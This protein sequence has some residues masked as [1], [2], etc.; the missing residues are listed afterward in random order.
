M[1]NIKKTK[2]YDKFV[3]ID[4]NRDIDKGLQS[5]LNKS[6]DVVSPRL[7]LFPIIVKPLMKQY[8]DAAYPDGK[9]EI[10]NGQHRFTVAKQKD[11]YIHYIIDEEDTLQPEHLA[12]LQ[13]GKMWNL[14][15]YLKKYCVLAN[16]FGSGI[17]DDYKIYDGFKRR[18]GW[19]HNNVIA[20]L[21]GNTKGAVAAFKE[22]H[23]KI[24][25][26]IAEAND[27]IDMISDF[28]SYFAHY[29]S[30]SFVTGMIKIITKVEE[31]DHKRM[32]TKMEYLSEKLVKCPDATTYVLLLEKLYNFKSTGDFVRFIQVMRG[33]GVM[34]VAPVLIF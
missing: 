13:V 10:W 12:H 19:S 33:T 20:L 17:Y 9:H 24:E 2:D 27:I 28:G 11:A 23:F 34:Q 29:K 16:K 6:F 5:N 4:F 14:D 22:G 15:N 25:R 1:A 30:R 32:M 7:D 26:S 31:Y 8:A 18:S 3:F 21:V